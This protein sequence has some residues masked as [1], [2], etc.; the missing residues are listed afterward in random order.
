[1]YVHEKA[2]TVRSPARTGN[3][4]YPRKFVDVQL[5]AALSLVLALGMS[6]H[7][8]GGNSHP[9]S[10]IVGPVATKAACDKDDRPESGVQGDTPLADRFTPGVPRAFN[11]NLNL[12][13]QARGDG[14]ALGMVITDRCIYYS[15]Q[16]AANLPVV[17]EHSGLVVVDAADPKNPQIVNYLDLPGTIGSDQSFAVSHEMMI[18]TSDYEEKSGQIFVNQSGQ[19]LDIFDISDCTHPVLKFSGVIPHFAF[20]TGEFSADGKT[21]WTGS[22]PDRAVG[23]VS[24]LDVSEPSHPRLIAQWHPDDP[25]LD[26]LHHVTVSDDGNTAYVVAGSVTSGLRSQTSKALSWKDLDKQP[27]QGVVLLD[28]SEV[29]ARKPDPKIK[30]I[31]SLF[32]NDVQ[33]PQYVFPMTIKGHHYL[34]YND[35]MGALSSFNVAEAGRTLGSGPTSL[36]GFNDPE[37]SSPV[38]C[39][40][41]PTRP[42]F[43]YVSILD[44]DNPAKPARVS[45]VRL[46]VDQ[47]RYCALTAVEPRLRGYLPMW[48][49]VDNNQD[50]QMMACA[51]GESGIRVFDIRDVKHPREIAYYKP[52]ASG[53]AVRKASNFQ[54]FLDKS[55]TLQGSYHSA[56][57]TA[58]VSFAKGGKEIWFTSIDGG[59]QIL[60]FSDELMKREKD[61]FSR[62]N[63]CNGKPR[64]VHGCQ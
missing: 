41:Y 33:V 13:G 6:P 37:A 9:V 19:T 5:V 14:A 62:D 35:L 36:K 11:C 18:T 45:G 10:P 47:P 15:Q 25:R 50:A 64:G 57:M 21:F 55:G 3:R 59:A 27:P 54:A 49:S 48:C 53:S 4:S 46:E 32:W 60:R 40:T 2:A 28:V 26:Y 63:S 31:S 34:W 56:D 24:A 7:S 30:M 39:K 58:S 16:V 22:G 20:H 12:V 44:I 17:L 23:A 43:G 38:A 1:M 29:Q 61:L 8:Y 51:Y 42:P 52:A